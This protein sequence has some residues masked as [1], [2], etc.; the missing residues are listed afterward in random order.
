M[1]PNGN[2][3]LYSHYAFKNGVIFNVYMS[4]D[5]G[6]IGQDAMIAHLRIVAEVGIGHEKT[7]VADTCFVTIHGAPVDCNTFPDGGIVADFSS[8]DFAGK[9]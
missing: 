3:L 8:C 1:C 5:I 9:F 6:R 4:G 7:I 2:K